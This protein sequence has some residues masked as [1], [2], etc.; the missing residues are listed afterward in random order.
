MKQKIVCRSSAESE[1]VSYLIG[2][3]RIAIY[4]VTRFSTRPCTIVP[5]QYLN[6]SYGS[7][8][9]ILFG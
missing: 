9:E 6:H 1:S 7:E 2:S 5:G 3:V 8:R 4:D